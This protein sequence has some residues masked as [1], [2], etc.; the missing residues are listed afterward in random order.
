MVQKLDSVV[1]GAPRAMGLPM[2]QTLGEPISI[3][4]QTVA[5]KANDLAVRNCIAAAPECSTP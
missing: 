5:E 2:M 4:D 1:V 3:G